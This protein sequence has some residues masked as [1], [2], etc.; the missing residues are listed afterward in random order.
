MSK[1]QKIKIRFFKN[2]TSYTLN[3]YL[4]DLQAVA[5]MQYSRPRSPPDLIADTPVY[6]NIE[7]SIQDILP[8]MLVDTP[9][10]NNKNNSIQDI[11]SPLS[12]T[13]SPKW[14]PVTLKLLNK[15]YSNLY[16]RSIAI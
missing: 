8:V 12:D 16:S 6:K 7:D 11:P 4:I 13:V 14:N 2:S 10:R 1:K 5:S 15:P 3:E 9:A